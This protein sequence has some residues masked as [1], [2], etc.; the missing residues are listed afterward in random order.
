M[1]LLSNSA[2]SKPGGSIVSLVAALLVTVALFA[3]MAY[4]IESATTAIKQKDVRKMA[5]IIMPDREIDTRLQQKKPEKPEVTQAPPELPKMEFQNPNASPDVETFQVPRITHTSRPG[6][7]LSASEGEYLPIVKVQP[8]YPRRAL[9]RGISGYVV[10]EFTVTKSGTVKDIIVVEE[11]PANIFARAAVKAAGK[12]KY[13]P[14]IVDGQA[15]DVLGVR[16]KIVFA[17]QE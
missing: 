1:S 9:Q 16:N 15:V 17:I 14:R 4:M 7:G 10:L 3:M 11:E 6:L 12:F 5:D 13:K 8:V 2:S